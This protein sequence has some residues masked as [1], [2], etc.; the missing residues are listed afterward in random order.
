MKRQL[1]LEEKPVY[2]RGRVDEGNWFVGSAV[3]RDKPR[4]EGTIEFPLRLLPKKLENAVK[5]GEEVY[6]RL[7]ITEDG[8]RRATDVSEA[9]QKRKAD[10]DSSPVT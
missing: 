3:C 10:S 5:R 8:E 1:C 9:A 4:L 7:L 6:L 2:V